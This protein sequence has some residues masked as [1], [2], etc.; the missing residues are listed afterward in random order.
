[1]GFH[2][3]IHIL[4]AKSFF[5][6][7]DHKPLT[8]LSHTHTKTLNRLQ[9]L[10]LQF[11]F[12]I[13]HKPG[14]EN[15]PPDFLSGNFISSVDIRR[16]DLVGLQDKDP[17]VSKVKADLLANS[18][19]SKFMKIKENF[20]IKAGIVF[21]QANRHLSILAPA[22]IRPQIIKAA[23][24]SAVGGHMGIF[25]TSERILERY[26]WPGIHK[27]VEAHITKCDPCRKAK[28]Y[29]REVKPPLKPLPAALM[30]N[31]WLHC[32]L[33]WP[34]ATSE[35]GKK[36]VLFMTDAFTKYV[37]LA[38][39]KDKSAEEVVGAIMDYWI[40]H[41][42]TP[43]EIINDNGREFVNRV[44]KELFRRLVSSVISFCSLPSEMLTQKRRNNA[45]LF[46]S[47]DFSVIFIL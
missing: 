39:I 23:H 35:K 29:R 42:S 28:P 8:P 26:F 18:Q 34:L 45:F 4:G 27:D 9:Q 25:K 3:L 31:S 40:T 11:D 41:Y 13:L 37:E 46:L 14:K 33:Y 15:G 10:M 44:S 21:H 43:K 1:M 2:S 19:D 17:Q 36:H 12:V 38:A 30:P 47:E 24:D 16:T 32:D 7:T 20:V 22:A 5:L 6:F